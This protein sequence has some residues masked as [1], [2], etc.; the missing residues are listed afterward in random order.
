MN[1]EIFSNWHGS[2]PF[3]NPLAFFVGPNTK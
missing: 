3:Q 1:R 2:P